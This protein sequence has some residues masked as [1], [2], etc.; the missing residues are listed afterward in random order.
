[1]GA[2]FEFLEVVTHRL[3]RRH[4]ATRA[5]DPQDYCLHAWIAFNG[6]KFLPEER[7]RVLTDGHR[8]NER[9]IQDQSI[10]IHNGN[11]SA[12]VSPFNRDGLHWPSVRVHRRQNIRK[13]G[14]S[15]V[16]KTL[17]SRCE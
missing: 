8:P 12:I 9:R 5:V 17:T 13:L 16:E 6:L 14:L 11:A 15:L 3:T 4:T 7:N 1:M 2:L 10:D